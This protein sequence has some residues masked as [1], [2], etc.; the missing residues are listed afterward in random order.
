MVK[1]LLAFNTLENLFCDHPPFQMDGN[2][3]ITGAIAEMLLQSH[4]GRLVLLPALPEHWKSSGSFSGLR[5]R[6]G[7]RVSCEWRDGAVTRYAVVADRAPDRR[8]V[9]VRING[10]DVQVTPTVA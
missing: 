4:E 8:P 7:Y 1:G 6:G 10:R 2:F 5:A 3:G 9:T